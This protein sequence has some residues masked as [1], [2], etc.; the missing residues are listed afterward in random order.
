MLVQML[1]GD[2]FIIM[3]ERMDVRLFMWKQKGWCVDLL[4]K[5]HSVVNVTIFMSAVKYM[6]CICRAMVIVFDVPYVF[7]ES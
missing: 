5:S 3:V 4:K 7:P 6:L 2:E 1:F